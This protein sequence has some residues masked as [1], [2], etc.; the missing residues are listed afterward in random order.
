[1]SQSGASSS[2][3]PLKNPRE[4][5]SH[6]AAGARLSGD[7]SVPGLVELLGQ[8]EGT[9]TAEAIVIEE[10]GSLIGE[11]KAPHVAVKGTFDGRIVADDVIL[12]SSATVSGEIYYKTLTIESGAKV[13]SSCSRNAV[14]GRE[15]PQFKRADRP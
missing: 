5:R 6:I 10:P 13:D 9:V 8:V 11:L 12:H 1:M 4:A 7:L 15:E 14:S 3:L 2:P